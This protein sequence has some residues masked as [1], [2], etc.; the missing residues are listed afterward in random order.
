MDACLIIE[1]DAS[2]YVSGYIFSLYD[3][4]YILYPISFFSKKSISG[5]YNYIIYD[6]KPIDSIWVFEEEHTFIEDSPYSIE[7]IIDYKNLEYLT[8]N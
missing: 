2:N 4:N 6:K 1:T 8:T 7:V 3:K 5:K